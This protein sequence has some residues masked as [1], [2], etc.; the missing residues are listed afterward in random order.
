VA[1]SFIKRKNKLIGMPAYMQL[2]AIKKAFPDVKVS[3]KGWNNFEIEL[4]LQPSSLCEVYRIKIVYKKN[5]FVKVYVIE[6]VLKIAPNRTKLPHVYNSKEQQICLYSPSKKE[7]KSTQY[8]VNTI[9]PWASEWLFYYEL[10]LSD[11]EWFGGGHNE[12]PNEESNNI[13]KDE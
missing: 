9:I 5:T 1:S 12:Y 10:W 2:S 13:I 7:W 8:I 11:G 6:R 4:N 3:N